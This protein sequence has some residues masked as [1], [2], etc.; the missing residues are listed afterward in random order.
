L[1][2]SREEAIKKPSKKDL[3]TLGEH[4]KVKNS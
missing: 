3:G 1:N 2:Q 4:F